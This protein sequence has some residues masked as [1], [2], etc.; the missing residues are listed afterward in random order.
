MK[1]TKITKP[2]RRDHGYRTVAVLGE[3]FT[4]YFYFDGLK[5]YEKENLGNIKVK[6]LPDKPPSKGRKC[7]DIISEAQELIEDRDFVFCILD[8]DV[9]IG[10]SKVR[11]NYKKCIEELRKFSENYNCSKKHSEKITIHQYVE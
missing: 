3:G 10:N 1:K 7:T 4:E 6:F 9:I 2:K 8:E 11:Q 5:I